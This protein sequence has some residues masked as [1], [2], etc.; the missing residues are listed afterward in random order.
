MTWQAISWSERCF[1]AYIQTAI[2]ST[3]R[4]P[5]F[6]MTCLQVKHCKCPEVQTDPFTSC[7]GNIPTLSHSFLTTNRARPWCLFSKASRSKN[8]WSISG[9][10]MAGK[11]YGS[12]CKTC[13]LAEGSAGEMKEE[14]EREGEEDS[15]RWSN[16]LLYFLF[17]LLAFSPPTLLPSPHHK[18]VISY[19]SIWFMQHPAKIDSLFKKH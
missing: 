7:L 18:H 8:E 15:A 3:G 4:H 14:E 12:N 1:E 9:T 17:Y 19:T 10:I 2:R 6:H 5:S 16:P 13:A 11:D